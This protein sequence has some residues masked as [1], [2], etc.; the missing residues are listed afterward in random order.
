MSTIPRNRCYHQVS[1]EII[2]KIP[3]LFTSKAIHIEGQLTYTSPYKS[4]TRRSSI[5]W[6][7]E[8]QINFYRCSIT[9]FWATPYFGSK[10]E[11]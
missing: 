11:T 6:F 3:S 2:N 5:T 9:C 7:G 10:Q 1:S 8:S 4:S